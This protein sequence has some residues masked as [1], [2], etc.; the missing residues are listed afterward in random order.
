MAARASAADVKSVLLLYADPRAVPAVVTMDSTLRATIGSGS[1]VAVRFHSEYLDLAWF[2]RAQERDIGRALRYK[3]VGAKFDLVV[4]CGESALRFALRERARIFPGVPVVFCTVEDERLQGIRLPP[5]VTGVTTF[6]DWA[7]AV[8]L[9]VKLHPDTRQ[10]VCVSGAGAVELGWEAL[11]RKA[12]ARYEG[13]LTF[14]YLGGLPVAEIVAAVR[15]LREGSVVL[16]NVFLLDG[17]GRTFSSPEALALVAPAPV[18]MYG[19]AETQLGHGIVGGIV[20]SYAEQA[21]RASQLALRILGGERL[22]P[23]DAVRRVP[24]AYVFDARQLARWRIPEGVLPSESVVKFRGRSV[25][26][27]YRWHVVAMLALVTAQS[28]LV[29]GLLAERRQRRRVRARLDERLRF[30][31][32]LADL[33]AAFVGVP[34]GEIDMRIEHGL[35][36]IVHELGLDR[37]GLGEFTGGL[38][39][40]RLTHVRAR[41]GLAAMP[42][43]FTREAWPWSL[44]RLGAGHLVCFSRLAELPAE[45]LIDRASYVALST[46]SIV[47]IPVVAGGVVIGGLGCSM[48]RHERDWPDELVQRLRLLADTFAVILLRRRADTALEESEGRFRLMADAA[49]VMIWVADPD[50]R[51]VDFNRAW[52]RFA[53]RTLGQEVGH[54]WLESVHPDDRE[55]C[56]SAILAALAVQRPFTLEYRLRRADGAYH[57]E[58][59]FRGYVGSAVDISEVKA[60]QRTVV[61]SLALRSAIFGSLYGLV[62][63]VDRSGVIVAVN[64]SWTRALADNG[65]DVGTAG[66]GANYF[67]VCHRAAVSG[68][69]GAA[70]ALD[71][72]Q[73]V[74]KA[75]TDRALLEYACPS[76][77]GEAWYAM[78]VE[79]FRRP[80]GGLV[81]AHVDVTRRRRAEADLLRERE[82]L[83]HALRVATLG[84]LATTLAH[85]IN[86]PLAAIASNAQAAQ[87]LLASAAVDPEV[88]E[89][90]GDIRTD[91]QRAAQIIRRLRVLFKKEDSERQPVD[92][93][94][95]IKEVLGLL[96]KELERRRIE[97][98]VAMHPATPRVLG[99]IVQLQQ[100]VLNVLVNAAEAMTD[101]DARRR[102]HIDMAAREAGVLRLTIRDSGLGV[103]VAE[104]ERIFDRFVTSKPEGLGMGLSISRSIIEAHGG[105]IWATRN[106]DR[107]L[108][109]HVELPCLES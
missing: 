80:E 61:E 21:R 70:A 44:E 75:A 66:V 35:D 10:I 57:V 55:G 7:A 90:L 100:V 96:R 47:I 102:L 98:E 76:P 30:E 104:L 72:M 37:A 13:R 67:Q 73:S 5:D 27:E 28:L 62:T 86:Q 105:R 1:P 68:D 109:I 45:A 59:T 36:R 103:A 11:A 49:P 24:N 51:R 34:V 87:R 107:G 54:G 40:L 78:I 108:T 41:E 74:L 93:G 88:P 29:A 2:P 64:E 63:A 106:P 50:G 71:A 20:V 18:P 39:E 92:V 65:G 12:L 15:A 19:L 33:A 58:G 46:K 3:Y 31:T 22:G 43:V 14:T 42:G 52:L 91:A 95:V 17:A 48:V 4:A 25:W 6:R 79:P 23:A 94:E 77:A 97:V 16:F 83:A 9:I 89:M 32:L 60:A 101:D 8:D 81:I 53:G 85:E 26:S 56:M 84:E 69:P 82:G 99:D 38:D